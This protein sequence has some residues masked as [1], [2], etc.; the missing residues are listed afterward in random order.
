[1]TGDRSRLRNFVN[2]FIGT[3]RFRNDHFGAIIG[4]GDYVI[5]DSVIS[6][7]LCGEFED[8]MKSSP[9]CLLSKASKN[10]SWL[11]HRRLNH[12]NFG[13]INDLARKDLVRGLPRLKFEKDHLCSA[14]QLGKSKKHTHKPKT[15]NTNLEVLNT[16]HMDLCGPM[17]VQTNNA[18]KYILVIID[19]Y[20]RFTW[21][22][23]LRS[24]D[25]T[26]EKDQSSPALTVS[27]LVTLAGIPSSTTID[28]DAP[29]PSHSPSSSALQSPSLHQGITAES[30]LMENNPFAPVDN[31]PFINVFAPEP[32]FEASS[33]GDLSSAESPYVTQ[34]LQH[35]GKWSKDH[36]LDNIIVPKP[37]CVMIIALKWI[38]K[39]KLDEYGDVLKNKARLVAKGYRQEEGIDFKE[40]FAPVARIEAIRI[41]IANAASK[42][43]TIYQM[44]V[45]T[46]FLNDE[47]KEEVYVSQPK[48]FVDPDHPTHVYR[49]KKALYG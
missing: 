15:E 23:F 17:R 32:S 31:D 38:Y 34:T 13:T 11:W 25:E 14:C 5:G 29:S 12:L 30:T 46:A 21:V 7:I 4:Y 22:K 28:Q 33:S 42:N 24:K 27:V 3:V 10:K 16:L 18:K 19:D 20:S 43:I 35:L 49:L 8:M 26:P 45:N 1:M 47:L 48:G 44:D 36:P 39:V 40:S 2:K 6:S 9:I 37:D 41:F